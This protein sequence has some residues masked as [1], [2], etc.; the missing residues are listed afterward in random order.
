M[1]STL[2]QMKQNTMKHTLLFDL[3]STGL[4]R[5]GSQIHCIVARD[6]NDAETPIIYDYQET[7][8]I[9][10]GI[11]HLKQTEVLVG[12]NIIGYDI[13]LIKEA[14]DFDFKVE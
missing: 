7:R 10:M 4:L 9:Q 11:E 1:T 6:M 14:Y 12:H 13:P 5:V 8:T 2:K 3:E